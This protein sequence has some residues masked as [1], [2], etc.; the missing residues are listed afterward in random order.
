MGGT[1][2]AGQHLKTHCPAAPARRPQRRWSWR[3]AARGLAGPGSCKLCGGARGAE[4]EQV[5]QVTERGGARGRPTTGGRLPAAVALS[6]LHSLSTQAPGG[7]TGL[8]DPSLGRLGGSSG[9]P[10]GLLAGLDDVPSPTPAPAPLLGL[11]RQLAEQ[12]Q[13]QQHCQGARAHHGL[14]SR[15][16]GGGLG[17]QP[18]CELAAMTTWGGL[19]HEDK[20]CPGQAVPSG[21]CHTPRVGG[22]GPI[23]S[24][25]RPLP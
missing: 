7:A 2:A 16:A 21:R 13:R 15:T 9:S 10:G 23:G 6:H 17:R 25:P 19:V 18:E 3:R 20:P 24:C 12:Q 1:A 8:P 11:R 5:A 4:A 14:A 22:G